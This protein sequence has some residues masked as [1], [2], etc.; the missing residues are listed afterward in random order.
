M[1][2]KPMFDDWDERESMFDDDGNLKQQGHGPMVMKGFEAYLAPVT[3]GGGEHYKVK[4]RKEQA[5]LMQ[6]HDAVDPRDIPKSMYN[7]NV[8]KAR[9]YEH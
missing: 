4:G 5:K 1:T 9:G 3:D 2:E 6:A 7:E 8:S